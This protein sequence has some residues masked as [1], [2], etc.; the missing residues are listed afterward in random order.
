MNVELTSGGGGK[1]D[2][3]CMRSR[4]GSGQNELKSSLWLKVHAKNGGN[5]CPVKTLN[6][7]N[8]NLFASACVTEFSKAFMKYE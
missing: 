4:G 7:H 2:P 6:L 5:S 1:T 8:V 3:Q